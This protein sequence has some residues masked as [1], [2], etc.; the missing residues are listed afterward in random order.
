MFLSMRVGLVAVSVFTVSITAAAVG[1]Y[2]DLDYD[3]CQ[4]K[5]YG[6]FYFRV[7]TSVLF[8]AI[9]FILTI[10]GL[11]SATLRI[12][13]RARMHAHYRRSQQYERDHS[14][15]VLNIMAY[16]LFVSAWIPYLIVVHEFPGTSDS[17]YYHCVWI[18]VC[19]SVLTSFIYGILGRNFR[20]AFAHL[21]NYCCCKSTMSGSLAN[22]HRRPL[23]YK[24]ATGDVRVHIMHQ[25]V[26]A[27]SP[28]RA[29]SSSRE[30]QEL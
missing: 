25:A 4:R 5:H 8:H 21:F 12:R 18:G 30:T 3:Y 2:M 9:P 22:R 7:A 27:N 15:A 26:H 1:V 29:A 13:R 11:I 20:R 23:E 6:D 19:R 16:I 28:Q 14:T 24:P 17:K 10:F